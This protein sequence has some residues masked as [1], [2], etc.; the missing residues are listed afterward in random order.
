MTL[1][2][3]P[4]HL[5]RVLY[6]SCFS[7]CSFF[8]FLTFSSSISISILTKLTIDVMDGMSEHL[9]QVSNK[10]DGSSVRKSTSRTYISFPC[11]ALGRMVKR[12]MWKGMGYLLFTTTPLPFQ[13][14]SISM[15]CMVYI[16]VSY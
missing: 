12:G 1:Y 14:S 16:E 5:I 15:L 11:Y 8:T 7:R 9:F 3:D 4:H 6:L 2:F 13:E 10:F